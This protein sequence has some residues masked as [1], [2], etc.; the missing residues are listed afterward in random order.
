MKIDVKQEFDAGEVVNVLVNDFCLHPDT[1][2]KV[3]ADW[4]GDDM[5][6]TTCRFCGEDMDY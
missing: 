6:V 4:Y 3:I 1:E 2:T 5:T